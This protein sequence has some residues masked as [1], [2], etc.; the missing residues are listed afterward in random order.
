MS[1]KR[2]RQSGLDEKIKDNNYMDLGISKD[3]PDNNVMDSDNDDD[4]RGSD[5]AYV[6]SSDDDDVRGS[7]NEDDD[8]DYPPLK[9]SAINLTPQ[10]MEEHLKAAELLKPENE[11]HNRN[12]TSIC[13]KLGEIL[14]N[15]LSQKADEQSPTT[16]VEI[17]NYYKKIKVLKD[18]LKKLP[19][20]KQKLSDIANLNELIAEQDNRI[21]DIATKIMSNLSNGLPPGLQ[22]ENLL[23]IVGVCLRSIRYKLQDSI[24]PATHRPW[25]P[26]STIM[27]FSKTDLFDKLASIINPSTATSV[28]PEEDTQVVDLSTSSVDVNAASGQEFMKIGDDSNYMMRLNYN[29]RVK[30]SLPSLADFNQIVEQ[31]KLRLTAVASADISILLKSF[32]DTHTQLYLPIKLIID[33]GDIIHDVEKVGIDNSYYTA[34]PTLANN[35]VD[36]HPQ[37]IQTLL[38]NCI[39]SVPYQQNGRTF[40]NVS[41]ERIR[42]MRTNAILKLINDI[43]TSVSLPKI[44][45]ITLTK[46]QG[47]FELIKHIISIS[48]TGAIK[49]FAYKE[50]G[51]ELRIMDI[52]T[53]Y[54]SLTDD[55]KQEFFENCIGWCEV[56]DDNISNYISQLLNAEKSSIP[57][58]QVPLLP[59]TSFDGCGQTNM[60]Q[61]S[62][63]PAEFNYVFGVYKYKVYT[64]KGNNSKFLHLVIVTHQDI[65]TQTNILDAIFG[66][67]G[68]ITINMLLKSVGIQ[69]SRS[70]EGGK[71]DL[72]PIKQIYDVLVKAGVG[73]LP[74]ECAN[75][76]T[77]IYYDTS[78]RTNVGLQNLLLLGNKTIGDLIVTT[79]KDVNSIST[80]DS[81]IANSTMYNYLCGNSDKLQSVWRQSDGKG[82]K[83]TPG[84]FKEDITHKSSTISIQLLSVVMLLKAMINKSSPTLD[85]KSAYETI[86]VNYVTLVNNI[87]GIDFDKVSIMYRW[88]EIVKYTYIE[89]KKY[90]NYKKKNPPYDAAIMQLLIYENS[91]IKVR[92]K[93]YITQLDKYVNTAISNNL[94]ESKLKFINNIYSSPKIENLFLSDISVVAY[95]NSTNVN[96]DAILAYFKPHLLTENY[97]TVTNI[98]LTDINFSYKYIQ[99]K[100]NAEGD[101]KIQYPPEALQIDTLEK[102]GERGSY[103]TMLKVTLPYT[104]ETLIQLLATN[105][106]KEPE[107]PVVGSPPT[108]T[109][110][111]R[112][113]IQNR[114]ISFFKTNI[115]TIE[116]YDANRVLQTDATTTFTNIINILK[117]DNILAEEQ[118]LQDIE[119]IVFEEGD[120]QGCQ[121]C[122]NGVCPVDVPSLSSEQP[123]PMDQQPVDQ[124]PMEQ[125]DPVELG[126]NKKTTR[127]KRKT[128]QKRRTKGGKKS[129]KNKTKKQRKNK[130]NNKTRRRK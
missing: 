5:D 56:E 104:I 39:T 127:K 55:G 58:L 74:T 61:Q 72:M 69:A 67:W 53:Y 64:I 82:W 31:I 37:D 27:K 101:F 107:P 38:K 19:R 8:D 89:F 109:N 80:A 11:L 125:V 14:S 20:A 43:A 122:S 60:V 9:R 25:T 48:G 40:S 128:K 116:T 88:T 110:V 77:P 15:V 28:N 91:V 71:G 100:D 106:I 121:E 4:V 76:E 108:K 87:T 124:S 78:M 93:D 111:S 114:I 12:V 30:K 29:V 92:V 22:V 86:L 10:Q 130:K 83:F 26:D 115:S 105:K 66:F 117:A 112:L 103:I 3:M 54:S 42:S 94:D 62:I 84:L 75:T 129:G 118:P 7:D 35:I 68:N 47:F 41:Q 70:G 13:T 113:D 85:L 16:S 1:R 57:S 18:K 120:A 73:D 99:T 90:E 45:T 123:V 79:Y 65:K 23:V 95:N 21:R 34:L 96:V 33:A 63:T 126:G 6:M 59:I 98:N 97:L 51:R 50:S 81:L 44:E 17:A 32:Y 102:E 119:N 52:I 36:G 24:V 2:S 49:P 46:E